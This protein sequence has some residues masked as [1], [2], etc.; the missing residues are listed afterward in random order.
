MKLIKLRKP[1]RALFVDEILESF[2][3]IVPFGDSLR[4]SLT[5]ENHRDDPDR[6][7]ISASTETHFYTSKGDLFATYG[8]DDPFGIS[9]RSSRFL[10]PLNVSSDLCYLETQSV[11]GTIRVQPQFKGLFLKERIRFQYHDHEAHYCLL[12]TVAHPK[13]SARF[14]IIQKR[15]HLAFFDGMINSS[16]GRFG[17]SIDS[18][19]LERTIGD[20]KYLYAHDFFGS[21]VL[22]SGSRLSRSLGLSIVKC[23][24]ELV[25]VGAYIKGKNLTLIRGQI[26]ID[27]RLSKASSIRVIVGSNSRIF[28]NLRIG[29]GRELEFGFNGMVHGSLTRFGLFIK[30][31]L[32]QFSLKF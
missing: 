7:P 28:G 13:W 17:L 26:G 18:N 32:T 19:F 10:S 20:V 3:I 11:T 15:H 22:L 27:C 12:S 24:N 21:Q 1:G 31:D 5:I 23:W 8:T 14:E 9:F 29:S 2:Q 4:S 16:F 6:P 25:T 30:A